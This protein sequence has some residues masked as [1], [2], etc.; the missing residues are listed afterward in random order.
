MDEMEHFCGGRCWGCWP[1]SPVL[2]LF[3]AICPGHPYYSSFTL[4]AQVTCSTPLSRYL[5][6]SP[7]LHLFHAI[8]PGHPCYTSF[9]LFAQVTHITPLSSYVPAPRSTR[10][11][12]GK[13][14]NRLCVLTLVTA[15]P[16]EKQP[17]FPW[18]KLC[19]KT[20]QLNKMRGF[21]CLFKRL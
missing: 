13:G 16:Q 3:Q 21:T 7:I 19:T 2:Q 14:L 15:L 8:C 17:T 9:T 10:S 20:N 11:L 18:R 5:P 4:F 12:A 1:K 6:R